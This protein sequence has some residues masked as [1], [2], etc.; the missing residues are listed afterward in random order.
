MKIALVSQEYPPDTAKGGI[1]TQTFM[2]ARGL[3]LLGH[4]VYVISRSNDEE[5][6]EL[7]E[8]QVR[9]I[10]I[11]G[12][13][14]CIYEMTD[15][16]QWITYSTLVAAELETLNTKV[17]L[18]LIDFPEWAAE[19]YVY[20]LNRRPWKMVPV[21][22][23]LHGPLVMFGQVM[24]WPDMSGSFYKTGTHME[25]TCVRLADRVY[26]SSACSTGWIRSF[27]EPGPK[28]IPTIHL[29][30]DTTLFV[31]RQVPENPNPT[32]IFVGKMVQNKG[33]QELVEAACRLVKDFPDLRLKMIGSGDE[34]VVE[35]LK[36]LT[37]IYAA[38]DLLDFEGYVQKEA[39]PMELSAAHVF[40]APSYYEG[41]P[42]F[43]YLEAMACGL[44]VI[45]CSGSGVDEIV[46]SG[47][48]GML[49]PPGN[50][51]ALEEALRKIL[52]DRTLRERMGTQAREYVLRNADSHHCINRLDVFYKSVIEAMAAKKEEA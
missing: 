26:S 12:F 42:G 46:V 11:P 5:R 31:P 35:R 1:G 33:V 19:G 47:E 41:G 44:P 45:G 3:S 23:Q 43:V 39:L 29:G 17:G 14:S 13:E 18:D 36:A 9:V 27:Y 32:I 37:E 16:V 20:F 6:H 50:V 34:G 21:V 51:D 24:N 25:A 30:V 10:R 28:D 52:S 49:V 40:A 7:D 2:K 22:I 48:T 4:Q 8:G 15:I 38:P